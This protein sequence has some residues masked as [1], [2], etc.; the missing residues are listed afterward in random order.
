MIDDKCIIFCNTKKQAEYLCEH[1]VHSTNKNS[2]NNLSMFI[3]GEINKLSCVDQLD[4]GVNIPNLKSGIILHSYSSSSPK[5][6]QRIGRFVRLNPKNTSTIH[7]LMYK[8]TIDEM[9]V[10]WALSSLDQSK[11]FYFNPYV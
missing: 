6:K 3:N 8:N 9:W 10:K 1:N 7:I 5:S 4:E 11:I 2:K